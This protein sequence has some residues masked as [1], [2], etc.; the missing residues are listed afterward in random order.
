MNISSSEVVTLKLDDPREALSAARALNVARVVIPDCG[1]DTLVSCA[2]ADADAALQ[3]Y[4]AAPARDAQAWLHGAVDQ[5][6]LR[7]PG[8]DRAVM[9]RVLA[10]P[11]DVVVSSQSAEGPL[12]T[13]GQLHIDAN[14]LVLG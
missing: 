3:W 7:F 1:A 10:R 9:S 8:V 13:M 2:L 4:L 14:E 11:L 6:Q 5:G 12:D